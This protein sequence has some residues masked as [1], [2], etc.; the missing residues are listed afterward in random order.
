MNHRTQNSKERE[1]FS[2]NYKEG[3][4]FTHVGLLMTVVNTAYIT[5]L[6]QNA[7]QYLLQLIWLCFMFINL[8]PTRISLFK[9]SLQKKG[10][11][12][13][14]V[15][16]NKLSDPHFLPIMLKFPFGQNMI[17]FSRKKKRRVKRNVCY[18]FSWKRLHLHDIG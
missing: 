1:W 15:A 14:S 13:I 4:L 11:P 6:K 3:R 8:R 5:K 18:F 10:T 2:L 7:L 17:I 12:E 9:D 16:D